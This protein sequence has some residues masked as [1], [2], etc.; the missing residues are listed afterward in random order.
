M[1]TPKKKC[2]YVLASIKL[3]ILPHCNV[4][5]FQRPDTNIRRDLLA[6]TIPQ[7]EFCPLNAHVLDYFHHGVVRNLILDNKVPEGEVF[8]ILNDFKLTLKTV[9][10][11]LTEIGHQF[12]DKFGEHQ[13]LLDSIKA[14][15]DR[16]AFIFGH[17]WTFRFIKKLIL[18]SKIKNHAR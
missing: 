14:I 3:G 12:G 11:S 7:I 1:S 9:E 4:S 6:D 10:T 18:Q 13:I 8:N 2:R 15:N 17:F 5:N 16:S